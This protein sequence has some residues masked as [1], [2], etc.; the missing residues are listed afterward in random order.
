MVATLCFT[1]VLLLSS[2]VANAAPAATATTPPKGACTIS[3]VKVDDPD[4]DTEGS[5]CRAGT[6]SAQFSTDNSLV[7]LIFDDFA[8]AIG[9]DAGTTKK[10]ALCKV[11]VTMSSP[12]WAFDVNTV[13]FRGYIELGK[14]VNASLVT[15]WKWVDSK[16]VDIPGKGNAQ[17]KLTGPLT[18]DFL[19][20]KDGETS[21]SET[22]MCVKASATFQITISA[23]L[24]ASTSAMSGV[25]QGGAVDSGFS[26]IMNLGWKKC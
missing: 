24:A 25:V 12:G 1:I 9:P 3:S 23:T 7:T 10:R 13:D 4:V 16:G 15:R 22:S 18:Q 11:N 19:V 5:G 2:I 14:G 20:H 17:K 8:A 26:E 6:V 21:D